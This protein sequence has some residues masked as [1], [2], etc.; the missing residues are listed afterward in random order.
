MPSRTGEWRCGRDQGTTLAF[1]GSSQG[2]GPTSSFLAARLAGS[3]RC[4]IQPRLDGC[5]TACSKRSD[6]TLA[7]PIARL[8]IVSARPTR[9]GGS[10]ALWRAESGASPP[11]GAGLVS[12]SADA[13]NSFAWRAPKAAPVLR[14][15]NSLRDAGRQAVPP[16]GRRIAPHHERRDPQQ[17]SKKRS[18][19]ASA[20]YLA[21]PHKFAMLNFLVE[22]VLF[23]CALVA[24]IGLYSQRR[25]R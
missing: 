10:C 5:G 21:T 2:A 25:G 14:A 18:E 22:F 6:I 8:T 24:P 23:F 20:C 12:A 13:L 17:K 11:S 16:V 3:N 7:R 15:A 4:L 19:G 1:R 9:G